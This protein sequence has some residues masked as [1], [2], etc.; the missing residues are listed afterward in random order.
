[1]DRPL[2]NLSEDARRLMAE[3]GPLWGTSNEK[4]KDL[5]LAAYAPL[6]A[7]SPKDGVTVTRDHAYGPHARQLFDVFAPDGASKAPMVIFVHGG[8]LERG[9][10]NIGEGVYDNVLYW[11]ARNGC[12][13]INIEYRLAPAAA[14]PNGAL[15][16]IVDCRIQLAEPALRPLEKAPAF[17]RQRRLA[18][19]PAEQP[20]AE[21]ILQRL[22]VRCQGRLRDGEM[23][24]RL[25]KAAEL[26]HRD[27]A[28]DTLEGDDA[29]QG[30]GA[31]YRSR[32]RA[33]V[34]RIRAV[35]PHSPR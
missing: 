16:H 24:G 25:A 5:V 15:A 14:Y 27:E 18:R 29:T 10:R 9:S 19:R 13:G 26:G 31:M 20:H 30:A 34:R 6:L 12:L 7:R 35:A 22:D 28:A 32:R 8:G 33:L 2:A 4:H 11:F 17:R 21:V 23:L 3:I 1:M